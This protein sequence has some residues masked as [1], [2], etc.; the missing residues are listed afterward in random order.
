MNDHTA[1]ARWLRDVAKQA[2]FA[3]FRGNYKVMVAV[4][5][6]TFDKLEEWAHENMAHSKGNVFAERSVWHN[7]IFYGVPFTYDRTLEDD[8]VRIKEKP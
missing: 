3:G 6:N 2:T 8:E 1:T 4:S 5:P 7:L